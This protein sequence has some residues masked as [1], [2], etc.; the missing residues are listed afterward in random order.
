M[1][2]AESTLLTSEERVQLERWAHGGRTARRRRRAKI[3]LLA[4]QGD[5]NAAIARALRTD[6]ACVA[7][8]R[9]RLSL[10]RLAGIQH[11]A[12]RSRRPPKL[13]PTD[14]EAIVTQT[15]TTDPAGMKP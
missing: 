8:W 6:R 3:I 7:R 12:P 14:L 1:P 13:S 2:K 9:A 15:I 5:S 10:H 11:D 4:A